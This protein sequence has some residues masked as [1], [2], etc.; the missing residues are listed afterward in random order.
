MPQLGKLTIVNANIH[1]KLKVKLNLLG[2]EH[3]IP[4]ET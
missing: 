3:T 4:S 1:F 2:T